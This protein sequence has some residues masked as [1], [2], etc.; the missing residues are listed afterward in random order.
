MLR[1]RGWS[2]RRALAQMPGLAAGRFAGVSRQE[3]V[4]P[5]VSA[6][7]S[8]PRRSNS[9]AL[10]QMP[11][12]T[13]VDLPGVSAGATWFAAVRDERQKAL[14]RAGFAELALRFASVRDESSGG[15]DKGDFF[16]EVW[17]RLRGD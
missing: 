8:N 6:G 14:A 16:A 5:E 4:L 1:F 2:I 15:G 9:P 17:A 11:G 12:L 7:A 13:A 3:L 10:A